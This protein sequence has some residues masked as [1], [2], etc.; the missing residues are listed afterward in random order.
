M[1]RP[2]IHFAG[3]AGAGKTT[4]ARR[5]LENNRSRII[6]TLQT[7]HTDTD[8]NAVVEDLAG[9][10]AAGASFVE[11]MTIRPGDDVDLIEDADIWL[12]FWDQLWIEGPLPWSF[13]PDLVVFVVPAPPSGARPCVQEA[14]ANA[15]HTAQLQNL[16]HDAGV[17]P[18]PVLRRMFRS[19]LGDM[20]DALPDDLLVAAARKQAAKHRGTSSATKPR[21]R[22]ATPWQGIEDAGVVVVNAKTAA[23]ADRGRAF[24]SS[25]LEARSNPEIARDLRLIGGQ[26]PITT[27]VGNLSDPRDPAVRKV[28]ARLRRLA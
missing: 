7:V 24:V 15:D 19:V 3:P 25:W 23:Q 20:V 9:L 4:L 22:V 27:T 10:Q 18:A 6:A 17:N 26:R 16:L 21:W 2:V 12:D 8:A 11:Q 28:A 5:L 13:T 1:S 14:P